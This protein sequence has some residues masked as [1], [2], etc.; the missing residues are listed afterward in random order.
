MERH[1]FRRFQPIRPKLCGNC[2]IP[3]NFHSMKLGEITV[4]NAVLLFVHNYFFS[5]RFP[6][7]EY[8]RDLSWSVTLEEAIVKSKL[9]GEFWNRLLGGEI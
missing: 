6:S 9:L 2:A 8:I 3:Q 7:D 5:L 4:H 1:S